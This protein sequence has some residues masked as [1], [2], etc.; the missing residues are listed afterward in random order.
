M[1]QSQLFAIAVRILGVYLLV[2][3]V[4]QLPDGVVGSISLLVL[5]IRH[6]LTSFGMAFPIFFPRAIS[7]VLGFLLFAATGAYMV[8]GAPHLFRLAG[9]ADNTRDELSQKS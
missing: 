3:A 2:Q 4:L 8:R 7:E 1:T 9:I 5:W 6:D